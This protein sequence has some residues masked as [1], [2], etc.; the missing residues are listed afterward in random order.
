MN[1]VLKHA[2]QQSNPENTITGVMRKAQKDHVLSVETES[3]LIV[4]LNCRGVG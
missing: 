1:E 3:T 2:T 4:A